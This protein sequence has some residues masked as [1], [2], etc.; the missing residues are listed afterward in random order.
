MSDTPMTGFTRRGLLGVFAATMVVA[1]PTYSNAFGILKGSGDIRRI[2]M[3]S[4]RTGESIDTIYWVEGEYIPEV[5]KEIN[6]FMRDWRTGTQDQD[7][8]PDHRYHG[9]FASP[10]GCQRALHASVRLSQPADQRDA[11]VTFR[12]R[13][14]K[15]PAHERSGGRPS[16]QVPFGVANGTRRRHVLVGRGG[17]ILPIQLRSHGLRARSVLGRLIRPTVVKHGAPMAPF[18]MAH[19]LLRL[20]RTSFP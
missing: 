17:E 15:F 11:P 13:G 7:R 20:Q 1:A 5:L 19:R 3:Y 12:G 9:G 6:Y 18:F 8:R 2:R 16:A 10:S 14:T 4:G